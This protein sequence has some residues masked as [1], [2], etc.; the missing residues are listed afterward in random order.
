MILQ[1]A[2]LA[3]LGS[4]ALA[5]DTRTYVYSDDN[6]F[7]VVFSGENVEYIATTTGTSTGSTTTRTRTYL[8][9]T[10]P[11][12]RP[13]GV[14]EGNVSLDSDSD[15][16]DLFSSDDDGLIVQFDLDD[17]ETTSDT[18][19]ATGTA[20]ETTSGTV[21]ETG[22]QTT[23]ASESQTTRTLGTTLRS[24]TTS[25]SATSSAIPTNSENDG[26]SAGYGLGA[27]LAVVGLALI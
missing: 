9:Y 12:T 24:E 13:S 27:I 25:A 18:G 1:L 11:G 3:L 23:S 4:P 5:D 6:E 16:E 2:L 14:V 17:D 20:S 22:S 21:S 10:G 15:E 19:S 26:T 8:T 7:T